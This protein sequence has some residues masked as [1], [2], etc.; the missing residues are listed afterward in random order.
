MVVFFGCL[1]RTAFRDSVVCLE[2]VHVELNIAAVVIESGVISSV[3][4]R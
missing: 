1:P 3:R 4:R 2:F